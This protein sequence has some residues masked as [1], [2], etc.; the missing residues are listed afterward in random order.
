MIGAF[1]AI[2]VCAAGPLALAG[3]H[4]TAGALP[5]EMTLAVRYP[6]ITCP[7]GTP[8]NVECFARTGRGSI[9]GL[10]SVTAT[11][12]YSVENQPAD[13]TTGDVRVLPAT[14]RFNVAGKGTIALRVGGSGC[15]RRVP[16]D[17]VVGEETFA[18]TEGSGS[19]VGAS[20]GGRITHKSNGP[21]TW[22]GT[23]NWTGTLTVPGLDFDLTAPTLIGAISKSV[24]APHGKKTA[25]VVYKVTARDQVDKIV[26]A[27]CRPPSGS[28]FRLGRTTVRCTATDKSAN[29]AAA[30]FTVT[31]RR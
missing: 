15:L 5:F 6:P 23:D 21:P 7:S 4:R 2:G 8:A 30:R 12:P 9:R 1:L 16:P 17:P 24:R 26:P 31:V 18:I 29:T 20:G 14:V 11:H 22:S 19:Y 25:R 3:A 28:A 10:G 13:C 27:T